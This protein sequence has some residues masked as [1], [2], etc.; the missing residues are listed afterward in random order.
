VIA[1]E[2]GYSGGATRNRTHEQAGSRIAGHAEVAKVEFERSGV[3][4]A[5]LLDLF[6]RFMI[7]RRS[8]A[9]DLISGTTTVRR[10]LRHP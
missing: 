9:R 6:L 2:D 4:C 1:A 3:S 5:N 7:P 10:L 8:T